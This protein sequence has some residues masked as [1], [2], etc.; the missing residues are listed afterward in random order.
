MQEN[1]LK[2]E[3]DRHILNIDCP[4][5]ILHAEDDR[6]VPYKLGRKVRLLYIFLLVSLI[7]KF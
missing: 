7:S 3:S 6:V 2:F 5:L 4:I 1:N